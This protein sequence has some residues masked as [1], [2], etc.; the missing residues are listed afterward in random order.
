M[1]SKWSEGDVPGDAPAGPEAGAG[2]E[3]RPAA[4]RGSPAGAAD[5][6]FVHASVK[7]HAESFADAHHFAGPMPA[8]QVRRL[9][10]GKQWLRCGQGRKDQRMHRSLVL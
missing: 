9:A 7:G 10:Q 4:G 8:K 2:Q 6:A 1:P 5:P 3:V